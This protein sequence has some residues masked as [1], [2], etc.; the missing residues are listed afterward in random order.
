[1]IDQSEIPPHVIGGML[2]GISL[3][4]S[5]ILTLVSEGVIPA[6]RLAEHLDVLALQWEKATADPHCAIPAV[7]KDARERLDAFMKLLV[8]SGADLEKSRA[9]KLTPHEL[10]IINLFK[11]AAQLAALT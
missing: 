10:Q 1:V 11:R 6:D 4:Q 5:V 3:A 2:Y 8:A 9:S 7:L